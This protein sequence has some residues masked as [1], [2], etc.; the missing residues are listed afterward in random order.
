MGQQVSKDIR[1]RLEHQTLGELLIN[2]KY[3]EE[4]EQHFPSLPTTSHHNLTKILASW[5][6]A[7][8]KHGISRSKSNQPRK[9]LVSSVK[10]K[11]SW[12]YK[13]GSL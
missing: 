5:E 7:L 2:D 13:L 4:L 8:L 12:S 6:K 9:G 10:D 1:S 11:N 3:I